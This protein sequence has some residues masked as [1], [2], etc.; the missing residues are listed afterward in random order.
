MQS[1][2][3]RGHF[4]QIPCRHSLRFLEW[5]LNNLEIRK[6]KKT[7]QNYYQIDWKNFLKE[8]FICFLCELINNFVF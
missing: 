4:K 5:I 2:H 1:P 6:I 3:P 7:E 8:K